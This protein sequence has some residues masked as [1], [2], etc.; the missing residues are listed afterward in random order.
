MPFLSHVKEIV[1]VCIYFP[2]WE[3]WDRNMLTA[4]GEKLLQINKMKGFRE[5]KEDLLEIYQ[6]RAML[7]DSE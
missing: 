2:V 5:M 6:I 7:C 3:N 4:C 1:C